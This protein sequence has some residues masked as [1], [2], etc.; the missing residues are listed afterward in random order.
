MKDSRYRRCAFR[1]VGRFLG[2]TKSGFV[3]RG[4]GISSDLPPMIAAMRSLKSST[5][6]TGRCSFT[7]SSETICQTE[8]R[9]K[10]AASLTTPAHQNDSERGEG[11]SVINL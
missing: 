3:R 10:L 6:S 9:G 1:W 2:R 4:G 5:V 11:H 8:R 7:A